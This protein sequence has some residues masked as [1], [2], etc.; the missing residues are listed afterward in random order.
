M[1]R[2]R[3]CVLSEIVVVAGFLFRL[4][5]TKWE[6]EEERLDERFLLHL[7]NAAPRYQRTWWNLD[8]LQ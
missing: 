7:T 1:A 8:I 2:V 6:E 3:M 5:V 4:S